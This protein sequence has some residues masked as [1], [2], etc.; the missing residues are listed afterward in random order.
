MSSGKVAIDRASIDTR[1]VS[2]WQPGKRRR[3][4]KRP[5]IGMPEP[6]SATDYRNA[7]DAVDIGDK[8]RL[9]ITP[10]ADES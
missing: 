7:A 5:L 10:A 3:E 8:R 9:D 6:V 1:A 4:A 2:P